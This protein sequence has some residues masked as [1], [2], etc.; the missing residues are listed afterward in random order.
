MRT[1][2][3][4][5]GAA[6]VIIFHPGLWV[7]FPSFF[8]CQSCRS[9]GGRRLIFKLL[10]V[11]RAISLSSCLKVLSM[12]ATV[13]SNWKNRVVEPWKRLFL[14]FLPTTFLASK[15]GRIG[16]LCDWSSKHDFGR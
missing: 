8:R 11:A 15:G 1:K 5:D 4:R 9:T 16:N 14:L 6:T 3:F 13:A 10:G 12:R 7:F 2:G